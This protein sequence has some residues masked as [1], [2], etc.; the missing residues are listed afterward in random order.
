MVSCWSRS[1]ARVKWS[2]VPI[3]TRRLWTRTRSRPRSWRWLG[4]RGRCRPGSRGS[5]RRSRC[6]CGRRGSGCG[7]RCRRRRRRRSWREPAASRKYADI[8]NVLFVLTTGR[9]K[10]KRRRI[11]HVTARVIRNDGDVI[12]YLV[13]LWPAFGRIE[14]RAYRNVRRPGA[15]CVR[16]IGI[17]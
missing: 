3:K 5:C 1:I 9:V 2:A 11:S 6:R 13:L 10:V 4:S 7:C 12:T 8:V 14:S 17:K 15:A 16:A